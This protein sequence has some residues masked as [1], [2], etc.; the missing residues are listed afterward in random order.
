MGVESLGLDDGWPDN[1]PLGTYVVRTLVEP[2]LN[3]GHV[4]Y[5]DNYFSSPGL[6]RELAD[7]QTGACGTL[8][9]NEIGVP[10]TI[11]RAKPKAGEPPITDRWTYFVYFMV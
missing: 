11:K 3:K 7:N 8:P 9:A 2:L 4:I 6:F 1:I 5:M 10:E